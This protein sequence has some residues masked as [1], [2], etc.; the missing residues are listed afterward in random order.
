MPYC[1]KC[2]V[3]LDSALSACPLCGAPVPQDGDQNV[4]QA[5]QGAKPYPD[6]IMDPQGAYNLTGDEKRRIAVEILSLGLFLGSG[7]LV[8]ADLLD[9]RLSWSLYAALA[10]LSLWGLV[11]GTIVFKGKPVVALL[12]ATASI[13][14][15]L[16]VADALGPW[17]GW[18]LSIALPITLAASVSL[19]GTAFAIHATK[20]KGL[21][22]AGHVLIG[23][24]FLLVSIETT[25]SLAVTGSIVL[26]W[27][28]ITSL[29]LMPLALILYYIHSRLLKG[30]DLRKFFRL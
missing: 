22:V 8:L 11:V 12:S 7:T 24:G 28:L 3:E 16:L 4:G 17:R 2:G 30:A 23:I 14:A 5:G 26:R 25:I 18:S 15:F 1:Y 13:S 20:R 21:N 29:A 9:A 27:S 19:A 10:L 6:F